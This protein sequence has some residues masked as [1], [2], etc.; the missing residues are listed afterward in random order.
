MTSTTSSVSVLPNLFTREH[1][2]SLCVQRGC[3]SNESILWWSDSGVNRSDFDASTCWCNARSSW[4]S[5]P[6]NAWPTQRDSSCVA[7][8]SS[9][10]YRSAFFSTSVRFR[11]SIASSERRPTGSVRLG[12]VR[13]KRPNDANETNDTNWNANLTNNY[14][15][16]VFVE[17]VQFD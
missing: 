9:Q 6:R 2:K 12:H 4:R 7:T 8:S 14:R 13:Q 1:W 15:S 3:W 17:F 11:R 16:E 5:R 10:A